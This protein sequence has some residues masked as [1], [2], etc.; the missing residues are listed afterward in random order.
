MTLRGGTLLHVAA[1]FGN[2]AAATLLLDHGADV[3]ARATVDDVGVGGQTAIFHA[4]TH[5]NDF[6]FP[7]VELLVKRGTDLSISAR[8]PGHYERPSELVECTPLEYARLCPGGENR[9]TALLQ[10]AGARG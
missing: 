3:N 5:F 4:A 6:G 1:E 10:K 7:I 9:T 2:L 8:I